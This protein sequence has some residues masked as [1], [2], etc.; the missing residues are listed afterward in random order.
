MTEIERWHKYAKDFEWTMPAAPAWKRLPIIR[1][2]RAAWAKIQIERWYG[3]GPG[4]IGLRSGY[5]DWV[6]FGIYHG[7]ERPAP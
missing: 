3:S 2:V 1:H 4:S 6:A 5:D 7:F